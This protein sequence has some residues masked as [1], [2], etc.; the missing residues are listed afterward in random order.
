[1]WRNVVLLIEGPIP[2]LAQ[3]SPVPYPQSPRCLGL[4]NHPRNHRF[5]KNLWIQ[6]LLNQKVLGMICKEAQH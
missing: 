6:D 1:M 2:G 5:F 3:A 4:S